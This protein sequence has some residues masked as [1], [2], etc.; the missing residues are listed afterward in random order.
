MNNKNQNK[1][2]KSEMN[3]QLQRESHLEAFFPQFKLFFSNYSKINESEY[4]CKI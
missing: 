2:H 4:C 3:P 1:Q